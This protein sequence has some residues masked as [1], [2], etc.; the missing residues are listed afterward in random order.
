MLAFQGRWQSSTRQGVV[1]ESDG[2]TGLKLAQRF[3][4][5]IIALDIRLPDCE[6]WTILDVSKQRADARAILVIDFSAFGMINVSSQLGV[7]NEF[8]VTLPRYGL[9]KSGADGGLNWFG[10]R[11]LCGGF[12][13]AKSP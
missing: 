12:A 4:P 13:A 11:G 9:I 5:S 8:T 3:K 1:T 10:D 7:R 2:A 6:G